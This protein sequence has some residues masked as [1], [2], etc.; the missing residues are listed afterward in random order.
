MSFQKQRIFV[1]CP[2]WWR[3]PPRAERACSRRES[4]RHAP[5]SLLT[6]VTSSGGNRCHSLHTSG[7]SSAT[8]LVLTDSIDLCDEKKKKR[9]YRP[10][11]GHSSVPQWFAPLACPRRRGCRAS[12]MS[13]H[14]LKRTLVYSTR[15]RAHRKDGQVEGNFGHRHCT[16]DLFRPHGPSRDDQ[17]ILSDPDELV[18]QSSTGREVI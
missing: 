11:V 12:H 3:H 2:A 13:A 14:G 16:N 6:M 18:R 4:H 1:E 10:I 17:R 7:S 9:K 5:S 15:I 8:G